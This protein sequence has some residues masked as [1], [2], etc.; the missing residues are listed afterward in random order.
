MLR[1]KKKKE[2]KKVALLTNISEIIHK[3][4]VIMGQHIGQE[5]KISHTEL[6]RKVYN[7]GPSDVSE[8]QEWIMWELIKKAL[9]RCRQRTKM[10]VV[11]K[12]FSY[13]TIF[14]KISGYLVLL[15]C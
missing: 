13:I 12:S 8:L 2:I 15:G 14:F 10:F 9:H 3:L 7:I 4:F 11:S 1:L 5:N 6:F